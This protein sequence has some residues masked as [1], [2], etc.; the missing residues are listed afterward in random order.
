MNIAQVQGFNSSKTSLE[1]CGSTQC[2]EVS[3]FISM[4]STKETIELT[5]FMKILKL[6]RSITST[7]LEVNTS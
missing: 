7:N 6:Y 4:T 1:K 3:G 5:I 2:G